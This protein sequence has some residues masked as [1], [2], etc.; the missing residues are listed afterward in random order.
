MVKILT[1]HWTREQ[2][3]T[4]KYDSTNTFPLF[5]NSKIKPLMNEYHIWD[6]WFIMDQNNNIANINGMRIGLIFTQIYSHF[7]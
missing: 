7:L 3:S 2:S 4:M 6:S 5:N 1:N